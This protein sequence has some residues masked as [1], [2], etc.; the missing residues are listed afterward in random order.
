MG[1][2]LWQL[3]S[4]RTAC[5]A[6][7]FDGG[8][9]RPGL[10][11]RS[12]EAEGGKAWC[13]RGTSVAWKARLTRMTGVVRSVVMEVVARKA[14]T[15]WYTEVAAVDIAMIACSCQSRMGVTKVEAQL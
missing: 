1:Q 8:E 11:V 13:E 3:A 7:K 9:C 10:E 6:H 12:A 4:E 14:D 2:E 15:V 5:C